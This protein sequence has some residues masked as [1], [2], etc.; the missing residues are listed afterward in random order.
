M[1]IAVPR[2]VTVVDLPLYCFD[3]ATDGS[4]EV[5]AGLMSLWVVK[6]ITSRRPMPPHICRAPSEAEYRVCSSSL[7]VFEVDGYI[8]YYG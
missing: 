2:Y 4:D 8:G 1:T 7:T 3:F 5:L 6:P